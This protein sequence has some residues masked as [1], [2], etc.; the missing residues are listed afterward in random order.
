MVTLFYNKRE[1]IPY[2]FWEKVK[3]VINVGGGLRDCG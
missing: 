1:K 2:I 3:L